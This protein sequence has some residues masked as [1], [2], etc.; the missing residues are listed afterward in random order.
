MGAVNVMIRSYKICD[1]IVNCDF[2]Y[3][4]CISRAEKY[5]IEPTEKCDIF[6]PY[7]EE[8]TQKIV[9]VHPNIYLPTLELVLTGCAFNTQ[10]LDFSGFMLHSSCVVVDN[11]AYLF[12]A[13][14]GTGKST[15]TQQ[16]LKLFGDKAYILNDDK[17]AVIFRDGKAYAC[18][19]PWSGS[20]DLNE[21]AIVPIQGICE[22]ERSETNFIEPIEDNGEL[23]FKIM[24]Q[25]QRSYEIDYIDKVLKYVEMLID[26][27]PIYRFGC[28]I[29]T[30][31]AQL[32]YDTM[33]KAEF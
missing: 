10:L 33:V 2:R 15:H 11:K 21:N 12:S 1:L 18:G 14:S 23:I 4:K 6:I 3:D 13:N 16:W 5:L 27:V 19:T 22:L 17:P 9:D 29:S 26:A 32:A 30:D 25:T 8:M 28:N 7:H 20:S 31:A 24:N